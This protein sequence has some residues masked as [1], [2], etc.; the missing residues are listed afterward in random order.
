MFRPEGTVRIGQT[1]SDLVLAEFMRLVTDS[2]DMEVDIVARGIELETVPYRERV[3][4]IYAYRQV[5][6]LLREAESNIAK[7]T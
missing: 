7:R 1:V 6:E 5:P 4:R 3:G 2:H